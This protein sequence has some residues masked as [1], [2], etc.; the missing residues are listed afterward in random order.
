[1]KTSLVNV[2]KFFAWKRLIRG[3]AYPRAFW[4]TANWPVTCGKSEETASA[5]ILLKRLR[6]RIWITFSPIMTSLLKLRA[7]LVL[8]FT[9]TLLITHNSDGSER[10]SVVLFIKGAAHL[11]HYVR[12][13]ALVDSF[14]LRVEARPQNHA[15]RLDQW[16]Y[17]FLWTG[18][19]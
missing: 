10:W 18:E 11:I 7:C 5:F 14:E 8:F 6:W 1:M 9:R 3:A 19:N 16:P 4:H 17:H 15:H 12:E 2:V 13:S